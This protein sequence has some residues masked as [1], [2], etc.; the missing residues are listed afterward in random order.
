MRA[1]DKSGRALRNCC[2]SKHNYEHCPHRWRAV[3]NEQRAENPRPE[4][5]SSSSALATG[6]GEVIG[7]L[8]VI[9]I[10]VAVAAWLFFNIVLP[11]TLL[12]SA[13]LF[14][15]LALVNKE[16]R[17]LLSS[18]ALLGGTYMLADIANGW[19]SAA[20]VNNVVKSPTWLTGF[21][22]INAIATGIGAWLLVERVWADAVAAGGWRH[23]AS[24]R[25]L[26]AGVAAVGVATL[27]LPLG[28]H[29]LT[30]P[31]FNVASAVTVTATM[32][33]TGGTGMVEP[34][35]PTVERGAGPASA[36]DDVASESDREALSP[37]QLHFFVT[38]FLEAVNSNS[39]ERTTAFYAEG[40]DYFGK[41]HVSRA[42]VYADKKAYFRRWPNVTQLLTSSVTVAKTN[43]PGERRLTFQTSYEVANF[44]RGRHA[45]GTVD[46]T[47]VVAL[48]DGD[49]RIVGQ[50]ETVRAAS[51]IPSRRD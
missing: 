50:K 23:R 41:G 24:R 21:V 38:Q 28:Y 1:R 35:N 46:N 22:Y 29:I 6:C 47:L 33:V 42:F 16:R 8:I 31:A 14:A 30:R 5:T 40:V 7:K 15:I 19:F 51:A 44:E 20:F 10:A 43:A 9:G 37:E 25:V 48:K 11:V 18:V 17:I 26:I 49:L 2:A 12:N 39:A 3:E 36:I 32:T 45:R 27:A 34:A 13:V 4:A